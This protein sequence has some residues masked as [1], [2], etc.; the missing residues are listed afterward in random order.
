MDGSKRKCSGDRW[1]MEDK[2]PI[3][4]AQI[5]GKLWAGGVETVVFNYYRQMD[6]DK[7]QFDF[8]YDADSTVDFP[9]ELRDMGA[10]SYE[11]PPYQNLPAYIQ[12]LRKY[13]RKN[14]YLFVHSHINS[15]SVFPLYAAWR[16]KVPIRIAHNHSVPGGNE[17]KR[18]LLKNV[19]KHFS[20]LFSTDYFACSEMAGRWLFGKK[21]F[22]EN[23]VKVVRNAVDFDKFRS[24]SDEKL[25]LQKKYN[26]KDK[27][28]VGHV[29]RFCYP[30]NHLFLLDVF[31]QIKKR[32]ENAVLILVGDGELHN[33]IVKEINEKKLADD[34]IL[35]GNV[36]DP[37]KYYRLFSVLILPS[38]FEGLSLATIEAQISGVP[39]L[40]STAIPSEAIISD[41]CQYME[42][43]DSA[44][45]WAE[46][47]L[48]LS[49]RT[50]Q[51][52][53]FSREYDIKKA[54]PQLLEW[55]QKKWNEAHRL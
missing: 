9:Q 17:T 40:I 37:E 1:I 42:L 7:V 3:R 49:E 31:K 18:N 24:A 6:K 39:S 51:L 29:G 19:L 50:V 8:F 34:V 44:E 16:E 5:M 20:H 26:L 11:V 30:K 48:K 53:S 33:Q 12:T 27:F 52:N 32:Q 10:G 45:K 35:V 25:N 28:V 15:L 36:S 2:Y 46:E 4:I 23:K 54:A 55:Y 22:E 43:T 41:A 38:W 47:A 13:F 14:D 21:S